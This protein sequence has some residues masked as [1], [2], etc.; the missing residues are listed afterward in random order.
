MNVHMP[1]RER[2]GL[3]MN[4]KALALVSVLLLVAAG[5]A[6]GNRGK[7]ELSTDAGSITI[8]YGR[9]ALKGRDML[10]KLSVGDTW[11][12]G[13]N[14]ATVLTTSSELMFGSVRVPKGSYSL[15]LKRTGENDYQLVFNSETGQWGT[16]HDPAKDVAQVPMQK[17]T[18]PSSVEVFT[19]DLKKAPE[20]GSLITSWGTTQLTADFR[21]AR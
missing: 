9:P 17:E 18:L 12:M 10:G 5:F 2:M 21:I 7:V 4:R 1:P 14:Q 11:R 13:S 15:W 19:I 6:Q 8:D 16:R 3:M 20:G